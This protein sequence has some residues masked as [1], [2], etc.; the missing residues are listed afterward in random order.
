MRL[1][2]EGALRGNVVRDVADKMFG[3]AS[4]HRARRKRTRLPIRRTS[5]KTKEVI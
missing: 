5:R 3:L 4:N 1:V 2:T